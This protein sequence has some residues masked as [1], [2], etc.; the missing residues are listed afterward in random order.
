MCISAHA[1]ELSLVLIAFDIDMILSTY[2]PA[3]LPTCVYVRKPQV[4]E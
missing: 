4:N 2:L 3:Y 1:Y